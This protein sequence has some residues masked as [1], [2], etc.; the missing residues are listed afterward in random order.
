MLEVAIT[1]WAYC[2]HKGMNIVKNSIQVGWSVN[3]KLVLRGLKFAHTITPA[4]AWTVD[5]R[6]DGSMLSCCLC[7]ILTLASEL[8]SKSQVS[9]DQA[10]FF[11]SYIVFWWSCVNCSLV[12]FLSWQEW[13]LVWS[14]AVVDHLLCV[15][16]CSSA[17]LGCN[18]WSFELL[19]PFYKLRT[20]LTILLWHK[21]GI[22]IHR[23]DPH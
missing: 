6:Q 14:S 20:S 7:Q 19:L 22:F 10:T 23:T 12:F 8:C 18:E 13:H 15:Q 21:Q 1:R 16:R 5:K 11:Q 3:V 4:A 2:G 9:S 17:N